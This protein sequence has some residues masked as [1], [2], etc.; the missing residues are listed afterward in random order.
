MNISY[1]VSKI[2]ILNAR[3]RARARESERWAGVKLYS[4]FDML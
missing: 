4:A 1:Y 2:I 3:A